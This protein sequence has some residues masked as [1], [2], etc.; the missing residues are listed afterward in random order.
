MKYS[1][2]LLIMTIS[3]VLSLNASEAKKAIELRIAPVGSICLE[4][5]DCGS[6]A[7][8]SQAVAVAPSNL[9]KVELSEGSE[10][11]VKMLNSGSDGTMVFEP[12]VIK[13]SI[14]DTIHFKATDLSH[15]SASMSGMIPSG[16]DSWAGSLSQD[17]S[18]TLNTEGV[19]VYQCDPHVMMA[20]V[21]V[22]QVGDAVNMDD[23]MEAAA[24]QKSSFIMN[25]TRLDQYLSQL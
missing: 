11:V 2:I 19:Y 9:P 23:I 17:I 3:V 14:G 10:H 24:S 8:A 16:A 4:G 25:G 20:M 15:N 12:A 18:I 7:A 22:I 13:V 1:K 21:G 5:Q 6:A